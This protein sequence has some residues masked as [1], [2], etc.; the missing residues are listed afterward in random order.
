MA[1]DAAPTDVPF[2]EIAQQP[3]L[4][5]TLLRA[6]HFLG[7]DLRLQA[8]TDDTFCL[9]TSAATAV[10]DRTTYDSLLANHQAK[11]AASISSGVTGLRSHLSIKTEE[12]IEWGER[13][14][15]LAQKLKS[16]PEALRAYKTIKQPTK[17][18]RLD[19][20]AGKFALI[21]QTEPVNTSWANIAAVTTENLQDSLETYHNTQVAPALRQLN[22]LMRLDITN[23]ISSLQTS[24]LVSKVSVQAVEAE[25]HKR[26]VI[27]H[28]VPP[29]SNKKSIDDNLYYLPYDTDLSMDDIQ[30]VSNHLL[31]TTSGFLKVTFHREQQSK[32][33]FTSFRSKKRYFRTKDPNSYTP[34][35][36]IKIERDLSIL[37][38]L[39]RQP[40][41]ALL[42]CYTKGT[43]EA[44]TSPLYT[45]YMK[46][47]FNALQIW[48]PDGEDLVSQVLYI[49]QGSTYVCQL[50]IQPQHRELVIQLFPKF[51][52]KK[53]ATDP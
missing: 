12:E 20:V 6:E 5:G 40:V 1:S 25:L 53:N 11:S 26:T 35:S 43:T 22:D 19:P 10:V 52:Q 34:D 42:D 39:E 9:V 29:F 47:D 3:E 36:P 21:P 38:R 33:F 2:P 23:K 14:T 51:F 31:T 8:M 18:A 41:L 13:D 50:A 17:Q 16:D 4:A 24:G 46:S 27:I 44:Q 30:S 32:I 37:E 7:P 28:G 45:E 48:S 49:P 15:Q